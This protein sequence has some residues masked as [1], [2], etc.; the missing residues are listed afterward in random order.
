MRP[1]WLSPLLDAGVVL[2]APTL[3]TS[4]WIVLLTVTLMLLRFVT[5]SHWFPRPALG[6][7]VCRASGSV[8]LCLS[9][10]LALLLRTL[11]PVRSPW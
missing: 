3:S 7:P 1:A 8:V 5:L 6:I 9:P 10:V 2:A 11:T 4:C